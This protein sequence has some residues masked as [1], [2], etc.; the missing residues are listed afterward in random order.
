MQTIGATPNT[1]LRI[2]V[3][4]GVFIGVLSWIAAVPLALPLSALVGT[5]TGNLAFR[6][7][8]PLV[9]SPLAALLWLAIIIVGSTAASAFPAW[10]ASRLTIRETLAYV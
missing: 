5:V 10:R 6:V 7:P 9:I 4:E 2:V 3:S 8:L 1:V